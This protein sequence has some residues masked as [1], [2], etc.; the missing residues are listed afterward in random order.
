MADE[1]LRDQIV[2]KVSNARIRERLLI[3]PKLTLELALSLGQQ[4]YASMAEVTSEEA[5]WPRALLK[6]RKTARSTSEVSC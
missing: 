3:E 5:E 1:M 2:E 6:V 4:L